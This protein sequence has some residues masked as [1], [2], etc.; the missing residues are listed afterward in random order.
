MGFDCWGSAGEDLIRIFLESLMESI[1][2]EKCNL[3]EGKRI[4]KGKSLLPKP[5]R[6]STDENKKCIDLTCFYF[7][8]T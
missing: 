4:I 8:F 3:S 5:L 7:S 2:A 6:G 1:T